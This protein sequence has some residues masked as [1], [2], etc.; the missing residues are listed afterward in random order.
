MT[1]VQNDWTF[2]G[3]SVALKGLFL[4]LKNPI[5]W[6]LGNSFKT[7]KPCFKGYF[8]EGII[9]GYRSQGNRS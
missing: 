3:H 6:C 9:T 4:R 1:S 5:E 8:F 7:C 2:A